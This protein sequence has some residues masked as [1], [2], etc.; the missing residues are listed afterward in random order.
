MQLTV[1]KP[2]KSFGRLPQA[3]V[4]TNFYRSGNGFTITDTQDDSKLEFR[5]EYFSP[6]KIELF[7][8]GEFQELQM[9]TSLQYNHGDVKIEVRFSPEQDRNKQYG[10]FIWADKA[11]YS[12]EF[13]SSPPLDSHERNRRRST[14]DSE[15]HA[16][17][18]SS[19][20]R[21]G[22]PRSE[23]KHFRAKKKKDKKPHEKPRKDR[24]DDGTY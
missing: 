8:N 4:I 16:S 23:H 10:F 1:I 22:K 11:R 5:V 17:R 9:P 14:S 2:G 12:I 18:K 24:F 13:H 6:Q 21:S 7:I 20:R 3:P 15:L 19:A